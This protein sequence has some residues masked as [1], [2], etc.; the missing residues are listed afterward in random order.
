MKLKIEEIDWE[1]GK[2]SGFCGKTLLNKKKG[3]I[4][5]VKVFPLADYPIHQHPNKTEF[6]YVLEG[7]PIIS[8]GENKYISQKG[9]FFTLPK[10]INH[11][12]KNKS[13][14]NDC[15]LIVGAIKE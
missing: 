1:F 4:K 5:L 7:N 15:L 9:D 3:G 8:I 6:I 11:S 13:K 10:V 14:T 12:I 2:V